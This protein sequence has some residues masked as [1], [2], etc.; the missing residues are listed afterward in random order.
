MS[1][2]RRPATR[3]TEAVEPAEPVAR[4]TR[5]SARLTEASVEPESRSQIE[6]SR[7]GTGRRRRRS[8]ESGA[9]H[10]APKGSTDH[11]NPELENEPED[12]PEHLDLAPI[13]EPIVSQN[14]AGSETDDIHESLEVDASR[15]QDMLD[16]DIPKFTRWS[17]N[18][19]DILS[20]IDNKQPSLEDRSRLSRTRKSYNHA[21]L[22]FADTSAFLI[23]PI[24]F[25]EDYGPEVRAKIQVAICSGNI[26]SLLASIVDVT[27]G[28][29]G[30]LPV[31]EQLDDSFPASFNLHSPE[32]D[33]TER[34]LDLAFRIRCRHVVELL[35]AESS[36]DPYEL[37]ASM[38]YSQFSHAP[39]GSQVA[40]SQEQYKH[41]AGI[42]INENSRLYESY[43]ARIQE[44]ISILSS[45]DR[46]EV[47]SRLDQD[48]PK[49]QLFNDLRS[50]GLDMYK[51]L[52]NMPTDQGNV[53]A[54]KPTKG[55]DVH[56]L[57]RRGESES[58]FVDDNEETRGDSDSDSESDIDVAG[59]D[60]LPTQ[61]SNRNFINSSAILAAVRRSE[62]QHVSSSI[63]VPPSNQQAIEDNGQTFSI[64]DAIRGLD[65]SQ[66]IGRTRKRP[67]PSEDDASEG[68]D[69]FEVNTQLFNEPRRSRN[70]DATVQRPP[71][72]RPRTL[73]QPQIVRRQQVTKERPRSDIFEDLDLQERD[74]VRLTQEAR[75]A[76]RATYVNRAKPRQVRVPWSFSDTSKLLDLIADRSINCSWSTIARIGD[77]ETPRNQQQVR[78]KA[79][80]LKVLYLE[81]DRVLPLGFDQVV[82][83]QKEKAAVIKCGKN[84]DRQEDD[85]NEDGEIT[86]N[87]WIG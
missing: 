66:V 43:Q 10:E 39:D 45:D 69:D 86:N 67:A 74:I 25:S 50:W 71:S 84:P 51:Q 46:S 77:F 36:V 27:V 31:L 62:N 44:I 78:D 30:S 28:K 41:L 42:N 23:K 22:P 85:L 29:K 18:M 75:D 47:E 55:E 15:I 64:R 79:R 52:N 24:N 1:G 34:L 57:V 5:R 7:R 32:N 4:Q 8:L 13:S 16:F 14:D 58:L 87:I 76:R 68:D 49:E 11:V 40:T 83:G 56:A 80:G 60:K 72:K 53:E 82:L 6:I 70:E 19:Y 73:E 12:E 37:A 33:D 54:A 26:I 48:C 20:S 61:E 2:R 35:T 59:Y 63:S 3:Q 38:F 65:P 81:S 9:T 17:G 21:R